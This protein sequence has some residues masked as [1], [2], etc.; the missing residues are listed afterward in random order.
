MRKV[1]TDPIVLGSCN[2]TDFDQLE[3]YNTTLAYSDILTEYHQYFP[4]VSFTIS[5]T[6]FYANYAAFFNAS[7]ARGCGS[8]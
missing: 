1:T 7:A 8:I 4:T 3:L 5:A 6:P 2:N